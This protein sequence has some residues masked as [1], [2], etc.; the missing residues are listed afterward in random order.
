MPRL[1][2]AVRAPLYARTLYISIERGELRFL[3]TEHNGDG[4]FGIRVYCYINDDVDEFCRRCH[5]AGVHN[6]VGFEIVDL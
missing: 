1:L 4:A 2:Q 6:G 3:L 5:V